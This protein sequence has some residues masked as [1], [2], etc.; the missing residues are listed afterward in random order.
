[1]G[2]SEPDMAAPGEDNF[3]TPINLQQ[4]FGEAMKRVARVLYS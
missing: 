1:M 4:G 2:I 3:G